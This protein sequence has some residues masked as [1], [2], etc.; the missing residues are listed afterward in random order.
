MNPSKATDMSV[1]TGTLVDEKFEILSLRGAGAFA[2]VYEARQVSFNRTVALKMLHSADE[3]TTTRFMRE[4]RILALLHNRHLPLI[5]GYGLFEQRPYIALEWMAGQTLQ[6]QLAQTGHLS[7]QRCAFVFKQLCEG[8]RSAHANGIVHRDLKPENVLL[9]ETD[10][11]L[12]VKLLDFGLARNLGASDQ[13]R[14]TMKGS[15]VGT[16]QFMPPEVCQG[17][18]A[19]V[20]GDIYALGCMM[21]F[22]LTGHVPFNADTAVA[23]MFMHVNAPTPELTNND[24]TPAQGTIKEWQSLIEQCMDKDPDARPSSCD[25]IITKIRAIDQKMPEE[26]RGE[27]FAGSS[28]NQDIDS[29]ALTD[30]ATRTGFGSPLR[31]RWISWIASVVA[32]VSVA[33]ITLLWITG[34]NFHIDRPSEQNSPV[35][36]AAQITQNALDLVNV[37]AGERERYAQERNFPAAIEVQRRI[38]ATLKKAGMKNVGPQYLTALKELLDL[39]ILG[40]LWDDCRVIALDLRQFAAHTDIR[41]DNNGAVYMQIRAIQAA[42]GGNAALARKYALAGVAGVKDPG[43]LLVYWTQFHLGRD[44]GVPPALTSL[45]DLAAERIIENYEKLAPQNHHA[46][47]DHTYST[48]TNYLFWRRFAEMNLHD[49]TTKDLYFKTVNTI[50]KKQDNILYWQLTT[51]YSRILTE[52]GKLQEAEKT[53][54]EI[55]ISPDSCT[56]AYELAGFFQARLQLAHAY[57]TLG[58][59]DE[60]ERQVKKL[61]T[62]LHAQPRLKEQ[63][64]LEAEWMKS[65]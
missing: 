18:A 36:T 51:M 53:L 1:S 48:A 52:E 6:E 39:H 58:R 63:K 61:L 44:K 46:H 22:C 13:Q 31:L 40:G 37:Y 12:T 16:V 33:S 30:T 49:Q 21:Y 2:S 43:L 15:A 65:F 9:E 57:K 42:I 32:V 60:A 64:H 50:K 14:L 45:M 34:K 10:N 62:T 56:S 3:E 8:L 41:A 25:E 54:D 23:L 17:G 24:G 35:Q 59:Q 28:G 38:V 7:V 5:Y 20:A 11:E 27:V 19:S 47:T 26:K 55:P 4:A 29:R